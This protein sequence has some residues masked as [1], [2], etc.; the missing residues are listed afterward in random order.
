ML[1]VHPDYMLFHGASPSGDEYPVA[2]YEEFLEWV[3]QEYDGQYWHALPKDVA[4]F[5]LQTVAL[6]SKH[7]PSEYPSLHGVAGTA[8]DVHTRGD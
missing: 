5:Y 4:A 2:L 8:R 7:T 1:D 6:D 3:K